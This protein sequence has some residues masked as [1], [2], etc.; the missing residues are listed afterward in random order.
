MS[1][2]IACIGQGF[3]GGSLTTV[4]NEHGFDVY[5]YD[6]LGKIATGG[7][8]PHPDRNVNSITELVSLCELKE[9]F[10]KIYFL[11]LPTPMLKNGD[12]D[13]SI[14]EEVLEELSNIDGERIV[15]IKSTVPP[16][17]TKRFNLTYGPKGLHVVFSPEF[18]TEKTALLEM[19]NQNRI[20]LGGPEP[21]VYTAKDVIQKIFTNVP[22]YVTD[23]TSAELI[24][25]V[26]NT[27][28]ATK[29]SFANEIYQVCDKLQIDYNSMIELAKLDERLGSTHW[30]VPGP[31]PKNDGSGELS[32][33]YSNSCLPKDVNAFIHLEKSL[34]L[35][36]CV[37]EGGWNKNIEV[38]PGRDWENLKG[39]A[40]STK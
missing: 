2:S 8:S 14:L 33:G 3:V 32:L 25:Y 12:A 18:L 29:V 19:R 15:V 37:I 7:I 21:H 38:R 31:T 40:I 1:R 34:G 10:T 35:N 13:L 20:I 16:R 28:F 39:R 17:T 30:M 22:I 4:I 6:I 36:P 23:E 9:E 11:C 26:T 5:V 27:F 24:K